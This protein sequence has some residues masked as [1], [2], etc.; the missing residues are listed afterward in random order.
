MAHRASYQV[1]KGDIPDGLVIMH[2]C[3]N[4][5]CVNP[6]HLTAGTQK[7]NIHDM[8][9]KGRHAKG[10]RQGIAKLNTSDIIK[11]KELVKTMTHRQVSKIYNVDR[12][13]IGKVITGVN[14]R[15]I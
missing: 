8:M 14:W 7:Q 13:T 2:S 11:I 4:P 3:D 12:S 5:S 10:E 6:D 1:Y 9:K 15:H